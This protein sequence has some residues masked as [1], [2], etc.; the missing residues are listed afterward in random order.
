MKIRFIPYQ[1]HCFAFGGFEIQMLA[2]FDA[3]SGLD[4]DIKKLDWWSR[5]RNFDIAHCWG[6]DLAN[7][8]NVKW[9]KRSGKKVIVTALVGYYETAIQKLKFN[10]SSQIYKE[11]LIKEMAVNIDGFIVLNA[12][13]GKIIHEHYKIPYD[14]IFVV[15]NI[16]HESFFEYSKSEN[17]DQNYTLIV[18]NVCKRKNQLNLAKACIQAGIELVIIG[19]VIGGEEEYGKQLELLISDQP[20][21]KWIKGLPE[22]SPELLSYYRK[23]HIFALPSFVEQQPISLLEAAVLKKPLLISDLAYGKQEFYKNSYLVNPNSISSIKDGLLAIHQS[24]ESYLPDPER[25]QSCT[26]ENVGKAYV[27][28]YK[29]ILGVH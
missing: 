29:S 12:L 17:Q 23:C 9:A 25:L 10:I 1:P 13:Q 24:Y 7:Y 5:D 6:L 20:N 14:R 28:A 4:A 8:E 18:G 27:S 11:R 21:I 26:S 22:N 19:P 3:I 16:V 15:P 2:A